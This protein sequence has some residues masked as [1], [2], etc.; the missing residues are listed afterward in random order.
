[1]T[2]NPN[3]PDKNGTTPIHRAARNGHAEIVKI[4][5][6]LTDNPNARNEDGET[7]INCAKRKGHTEI[8][9]I[10]SKINTSKDVV[11]TEEP[12]PNPTCPQ[13]DNEVGSQEKSMDTGEEV[14]PQ[15]Q[16]SRPKVI[17]KPKVDRRFDYET[18]SEEENGKV[19][20][21]F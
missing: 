15:A 13:F 3:A 17:P 21:Q 18:D 16:V 6:P 9:E 7:P 2:D 11:M 14:L 12:A 20:S 5:V 8:V 10:L 1:M 4:L 19:T